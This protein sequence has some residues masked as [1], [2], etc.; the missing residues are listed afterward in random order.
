MF[1]NHYFNLAIQVYSSMYR[2][3]EVVAINISKKIIEVKFFKGPESIIYDFNGCVCTPI[4]NSNWTV[5]SHRTLFSNESECRDFT[6]Y[7]A[8]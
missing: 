4:P 8:A 1:E 6:H 7:G 3:G 5:D 2:W